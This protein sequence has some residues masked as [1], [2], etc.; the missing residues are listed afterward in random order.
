MLQAQAIL[1]VKSA[2]A[3]RTKAEKN[4]GR[5]ANIMVAVGCMKIYRIAFSCSSGFAFSTVFD[6]AKLTPLSCFLLALP[7]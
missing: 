7:G 1:V 5:V 4:R 6:V 3:F 2:V